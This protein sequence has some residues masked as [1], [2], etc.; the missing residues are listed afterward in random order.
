MRTP[1]S[2]LSSAFSP[3]AHLFLAEL[4][5]P[6]VV[7]SLLFAPP[8]RPPSWIPRTLRIIHRIR[9]THGDTYQPLLEAPISSFI[10]IV[11]T[12]TKSDRV[13]SLRT[14]PSSESRLRSRS[15]SYYYD[16]WPLF[17]PPSPV[18]RKGELS[19]RCLALPTRTQT[20]HVRIDSTSGV[21]LWIHSYFSIQCKDHTSY[22]R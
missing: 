7:A 15:P 20:S 8:R 6:I 19:G 13:A 17:I 21:Y 11:F 5:S 2:L 3:S 10:Q 14:S 12:E 18:L 16:S 22:P 4:L 1:Y 9:P